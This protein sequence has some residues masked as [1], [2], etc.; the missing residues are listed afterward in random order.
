MKKIYCQTA[1]NKEIKKEKLSKQDI[2]M[3]RNNFP[4]FQALKIDVLDNT[5]KYYVKRW[6]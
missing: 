4:M 5:S 6:L 2:V 3:I 1:N